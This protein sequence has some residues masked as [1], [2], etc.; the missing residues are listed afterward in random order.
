M[1]SEAPRRGLLDTNIMILRSRI[2][3]EDLPDEM[4]ISAVTVASPARPADIVG[5]PWRPGAGRVSLA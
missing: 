2:A 1:I 3:P 5:M 4:A